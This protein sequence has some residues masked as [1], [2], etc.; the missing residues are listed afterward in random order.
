MKKKYLI[1]G[2]V[3]LWLIFAILKNQPTQTPNQIAS[4]SSVHPTA[5]PTP[6]PMTFDEKVKAAAQNNY[7]RISEVK[8]DDAVNLDT[9]AVIPGKKNVNIT[10]L[11]NNAV[12][13]DMAKR[14]G[15]RMTTAI[16]QKLFPIDSNIFS[17]TITTNMPAVD[18]YGK[19][20]QE[21]LQTLI[22]TRDTFNKINFNNFDY[23]NIPSI[24][25]TYSE[26]HAAN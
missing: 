7:G 1:I 17:V 14:D 12:G 9:N 23:L 3:A 16:I 2:A 15:M 25:D 5:I 6:K 4:V 22:I 18:V 24:A 19:N 13:S 11:M 26:N 8:I 10:A 21:W 20:N